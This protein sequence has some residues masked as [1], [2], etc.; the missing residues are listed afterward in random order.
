M[1]KVCI[2]QKMGD[3]AVGSLPSAYQLLLSSHTLPLVVVVIK[4]IPVCL[5][6]CPLVSLDNPTLPTPHHL[7]LQL[8]I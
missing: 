7:L 5:L 3:L 6:P 8:E 2:E 4:E 1:G